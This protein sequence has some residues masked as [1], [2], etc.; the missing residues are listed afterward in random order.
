MSMALHQY[1]VQTLLTLAAVSP[2]V[3][4]RL[5]FRHAMTTFLLSFYSINSISLK[6]QIRYRLNHHMLPSGEMSQSFCFEDSKAF[7][8]YK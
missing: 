5:C 2:S 6:T 1:Q 4:Q 8:V 3:M 7:N